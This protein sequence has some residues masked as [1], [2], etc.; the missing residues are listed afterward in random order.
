M[1]VIPFLLAALG[2][3][4]LG[5]LVASSWTGVGDLSLARVWAYEFRREEAI[6]QRRET[7]RLVSAGKREVVTAVI[8]GRVTLREAAH[9]FG[10]L[11]AR[12]DDGNDD[13][14]GPA[15]RHSDEDLCQSVLAWVEV[16]LGI[17][18]GETPGPLARLQAEHRQRFG[19]D[20]KPFLVS[21]LV[22]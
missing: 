6:D 8:A 17:K 18:P 13:V 22:P 7:S 15:P 14:L 16:E 5:T 21:P 10:E 9:S 20:P 4:L 12:Y 3:T 19:H 1:R 2:L 11:N